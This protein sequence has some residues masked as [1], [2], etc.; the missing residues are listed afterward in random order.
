MWAY[1]SVF[2]QLYPLGFCG[3]PWENDGTAYSRI[4]KITDW[5]PHIISMNADALYLSPVFE[6]DAHGYDTRDYTKIDSRLGTNEEFAAVCRELHR[7]GIRVV[8]DGVFHHVGRGFWAF[9]DVVE[10]RE[11]SPYRDWFFLD[12]G[13]D[14]GYGDGLWYEGW[15]GHYELVKLNLRNGELVDYLLSCVRGWVEQF[16]IDGLR[17]DVAYSLDREFLSRLR[18]FCDGLK[19]EFFLVGEMLHG[20][21]RLLMRE[22]GLHSVT[23][24]ECYKG[25]YSS[26]NSRNLFE[27]A[28]SLGRQ[29]GPEDWTLYKGLHLFNFVDN[30]DVSRIAT[31]LTRWEHLR[32]IYALLFSMPGI[33][34]VY[35]GSEWGA[36][37][38]K[39]QG[40]PRLRPAFDK[41]VDNELS[42]WVA[43]L[44]QAHKRSRALCHGSFRVLCLTNEQLVFEREGEGERVIAAI[45]A[46]DQPYTAHFDARGGRGTD[47]LTGKAHDFGGGSGLPPLSAALWRVD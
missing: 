6:S 39:A 21:Y 36:E 41:P 8:L 40:D 22:G 1:D 9:R 42:R 29:F 46:A 18:A 27:I 14:S 37:G 11:S 35:Y 5:I 17:L 24:Y 13:R 47:L 19:P 30:H 20:D 3:A 23:N 16:D 4:S 10:K 44:A 45:N 28:H 7:S 33:P 31:L 15:E 38:D 32:L 2:Y 34:C 25:M 43:A 26:F 12:F